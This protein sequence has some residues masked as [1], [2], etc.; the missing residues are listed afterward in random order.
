MVKSKKLVK[1]LKENRKKLN[2]IIA[3]EKFRNVDFKVE[4]FIKY[5]IEISEPISEYK[6]IDKEK[7]EI[8]ILAVYE[9]LLKLFSKAYL[10]NPGKYPYLED[11]LKK[12][13]I[14]FKNLVVEN[15]V[16]FISAMANAVLKIFGQIGEKVGS[17]VDSLLKFKDINSETLFEIGF[18][19]AW[20][21]GITRY[22][23]HAISICKKLKPEILGKIFNSDISKK[24]LARMEADA[25]LG[26]RLIRHYAV[27]LLKGSGRFAALCYTY[28]LKRKDAFTDSILNSWLDTGDAGMGDAF[29]AGLTEI[30]QDEIDGAIHPALEEKEKNTGRPSE[31]TDNIQS[32]GNY[33]EPF[34]YGQILKSI[35]LNLDD[36]EIAIKY[37][38]ERAIK[39]LIPF[40]VQI[41]ETSKE[42]LAEGFNVWD[43]GSPIEKINWIES[44]IKSPYIVPGYTTVEQIYGTTE[45]SNLDKEPVD[46]DLYVDCSGSMPNPTVKVS[47]LTLAGAIIAI[48]ALRSGSRVQATLWSGTNQFTTTDGFIGEE[49]S[50]LGILTGY[51]GDGT[52][53]PIHMLRD[54]YKARKSSDRKVH[55][56]VI[57]DSGVT[58][59][60]NKDEQNNSGYDIAGK[61]LE[62]AQGGGTFVLQLWRKWKSDP[63]LV[64]AAKQGW[65]IYTIS[66]W[67][68]LIDFSKAF[69]KKHYTDVEVSL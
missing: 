3:L 44:I 21:A 9:N 47:Y 12:V 14:S 68:D 13:I 32:R 51:F 6:N 25:V 55:I 8:S 31:E 65:D 30:E 38:K 4:E 15:P 66:D 35:G 20:R 10:G 40:P 19:L 60:Y 59:I 54:T 41:K 36:K 46:L 49:K 23:K 24:K 28:L 52:A 33:R 56:L 18:V 61:A 29:P 7:L 27:D 39:N 22:R 16:F 62:K 50:I 17:W 57:S 63:L 11:S 64:D 58:T 1:I 2:A 26:N 5:F 45:G 48:S 69:S 34:E 53:F 43:I 67:E 37:Y 42:P